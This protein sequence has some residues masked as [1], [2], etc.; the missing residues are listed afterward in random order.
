M[1]LNIIFHHKQEVV[2]LFLLL[3]DTKVCDLKQ[4][5]EHII[6][7]GSLEKNLS[8]DNISCVTSLNKAVLQFGK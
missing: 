8:S 7:N 6:G 3:S 4:H 5:G 2:C 1:Y